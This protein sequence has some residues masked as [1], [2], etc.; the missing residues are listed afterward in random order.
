MIMSRGYR[1][2]DFTR[3]LIRLKKDSTKIAGRK[4]NFHYPFD[5][6]GSG[7]ID[8]TRSIRICLEDS[9]FCRFKFHLIPR[10]VEQSA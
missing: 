4:L 6:P 9:E 1:F 10:T 2:V 7:I 3:V 8:T 5:E